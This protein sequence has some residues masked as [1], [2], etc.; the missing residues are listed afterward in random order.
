MLRKVDFVR[1]VIDVRCTCCIAYGALHTLFSV[2][3]VVFVALRNMHCNRVV[4]PFRSLRFV[5]I[6]NLNALR[7]SRNV[8][9]V[10]FYPVLFA[11][12]VAHNV[13]R[14]IQCA[15]VALHGA[16][17]ALRFAWINACVTLCL[18]RLAFR[19]ICYARCI[20]LNSMRMFRCVE[21]LAR[22]AYCSKRIALFILPHF[23]RP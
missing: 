2:L 3:C 19:Q 13:L 17:C 23:F 4:F 9:S 22:V 7:F 6:N 18:M 10:A 14:R 15:I 11:S 5:S 21:S 8:A 12:C 1:C 16:L 20:A